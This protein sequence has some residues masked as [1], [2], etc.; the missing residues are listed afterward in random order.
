MAFRL[1]GLASAIALTAGAAGQP[2]DGGR[3]DLP[4][5]SK[6]LVCDLLPDLK[7]IGGHVLDKVEGLAITSD[8]EA[9]VSTGNDGV[10]DSSV[11]AMFFSIGKVE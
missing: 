7:A 3:G 5:V 10:G 8:G 11:E 6:E 4:V 2:G 1:L 9:F